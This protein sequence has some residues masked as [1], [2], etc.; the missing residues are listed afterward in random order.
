MKNDK[1]EYYRPWGAPRSVAS[2][3]EVR[4]KLIDTI[5]SM[6]EAREGFTDNQALEYLENHAGIKSPLERDAILTAVKHGSLDEI[7]VQVAA[8]AQNPGL[9]P[10]YPSRN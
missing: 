9:S 1:G 6:F 7:E 10:V 5:R 4:P 3:S 2:V 8:T